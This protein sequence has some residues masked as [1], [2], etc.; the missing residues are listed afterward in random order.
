MFLELFL[1]TTPHPAAA[2]AGMLPFILVTTFQ[3][4]TGWTF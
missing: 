1:K 4:R 3:S 2:A